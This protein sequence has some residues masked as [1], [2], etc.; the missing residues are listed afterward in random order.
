MLRLAGAVAL[1]GGA[2]RKKARETLKESG[3][4]IRD[5][6]K[7]AMHDVRDLAKKALR[8]CDESGVEGL[9]SRLEHGLDEVAEVH[10]EFEKERRASGA[11]VLVVTMSASADGLVA[12][13]RQRVQDALDELKDLLM[14]L[15]KDLR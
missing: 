7:D 13:Y 15:A 3:H 10:E 9:V 1:T 14:D 8:D 6:L 11:S 12:P 5:L 2:E 4:D